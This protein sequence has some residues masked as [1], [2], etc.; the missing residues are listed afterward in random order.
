MRCL[1]TGGAGLVGSHVADALAYA[2]HEP[3]IYDSLVSPTHA[4]AEWPAWSVAYERYRWDVRDQRALQDAMDG[5]DVV[6]HQAAFGG[7]APLPIHATEINCGGTAVVMAAA[8]NAGVRKVVVASSQAV[9]GHGSCTCGWHYGQSHEVVREPERLAAGDWWPHCQFDDRRRPAE[10]ARFSEDDPVWPRSPY[11]LSK[12][13]AEQL[14][15]SLG[16]EWGLPVVA[17]R[18]ALT[19]GP[20]QSPSNPYTGIGSIFATRLLNDLPPVIYEDGDQLRDFVYVEDVADA[21]LL[22]AEDERA[23]GRVFNVGLGE[24]Q[25]VRAFCWELA[26]ALDRAT[27]GH[28]GAAYRCVSAARGDYRPADARYVVTDPSHLQQL[29]WW[30]RVDLREGLSRFAEWIL[31]QPKPTEVFA[32]AERELV[33]AGVVKSTRSEA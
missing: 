19:Y 3:V 21:N 13:Y 14:A 5:C 16:A 22:V 33:H 31:S 9:Y 17:L 20:R 18:Y 7:F 27:G 25:T 29:G 10:I 11:A 28:A 6:F 12:W 4:T 24:P 15:L 32:Q 8:R 26:A 2:G 23:D 1:I 30:P